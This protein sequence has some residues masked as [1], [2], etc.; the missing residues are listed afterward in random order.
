MAAKLLD[1]KALAA[2]IKKGLLADVS[3][4]RI[5][6]KRSPKLVSVQ[7]GEDPASEI[8]LKSQRKNAEALGIEYS[9]EKLDAKTSQSDLI[10]A[11][12]KLNKDASVS[13]IIVQMPIPQHI[14][15]K[16]ISR[17]ISPLKD[18]EAVHPQNMGEIVF[19]K[20]KILPCTAAACMELLNSIDSLDLYGKEA[21]V[22][23]HSEIVGKPLALLLLNKFV[24]TTVCHIATGERGALP[25]FVKK[26]EILIVACGKACLVKGDWIKEGAIV[27]DVGI[28]RVEGKIVGDVEFDKAQEK[29]SYITPV[30]G[31]V[32]PLTVAMLMKNVVEAFKLQQ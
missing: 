14:D 11:I 28:N 8:Y 22:V 16:I 9:L 26:A 24:T 21:V 13:G 29:A 30:P 4:L 32:G 3:S 23:G 18:I 10:K 5:R 20:A 12:D 15:G 6:Y 2:K 25:D 19:G 17:Y 1:G 31:G 7:V 27:I